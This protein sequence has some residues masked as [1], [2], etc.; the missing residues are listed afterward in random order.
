MKTHPPAAWT[1][2]VGFSA[3]LL[4]G[5]SNPKAQDQ[6][7]R[8]RAWALVKKEV[9]HGEVKDKKVYISREPLQAGEG[10]KS[11]KEVYH[12][13]RDFPSAWLVFIDDQPEANW[14]HP[15]R[16]VF[17]NSR[18]GKHQIIESQPPPT[19]IDRMIRIF[20]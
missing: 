6:I 14:E 3:F 15:C 12:V 9:L 13:P 4:V 8:E 16:Y 20:P 17:V 11:W 2:I 5:L 1:L 18:S 19:R 10:I 7:H